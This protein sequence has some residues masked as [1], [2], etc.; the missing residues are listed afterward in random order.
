MQGGKNTPDISALTA[1]EKRVLTNVLSAFS[2]GNFAHSYVL[3]GGS[4]ASRLRCAEII[5][6]AAVCT[7]MQETHGAYPCFSC[8]QCRKIL[9]REHTD[10]KIISPEKEAGKSKIEIRVDTIRNVRKEAYVLPTDCEYHIYIINESEKMNVNAQNAL[11]KILEEPPQNTIFIL[12]A[13]SKELLLPTVVSRVQSHTLGK[14]SVEETGEVFAAKFPSLPK[15]SVKRAARLQ[16]ALDKIEH[17]A[18]NIKT[19]DAA[20]G[21]VRQYF[22]EKNHRLTESLPT[23]K[24]ELFLSLCV[25][26]MASRDIAVSKKNENQILFV[27]EKGPEFDSAKS[28]VSMRRAMEL[29]EAFS[30]AAER[31]QA[32]G[33][34]GSVLAELF[35][36][37]RK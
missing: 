12:L 3:E 31:V 24:D 1:G 14:S 5:A 6:C 26:A 36:A 28:S 7:E 2:N 37:V 9:D 34:V 18:A 29:Y 17:D 13:P 19:I 22:L 16:C 27:F 30:R 4:G 23:S 11:L 15:E 20:Y 25:L 8:D 35:S 33:N 10:I 21:L 32:A